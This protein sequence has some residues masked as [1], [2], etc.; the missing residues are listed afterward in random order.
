MSL[1]PTPAGVVKENAPEACVAMAV[2]IFSLAQGSLEQVSWLH[3]LFEQLRKD[4][5]LGEHQCISNVVRR[6][7]STVYYA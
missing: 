4:H 5:Y 3:A 6:C 7:K 1:I 2:L